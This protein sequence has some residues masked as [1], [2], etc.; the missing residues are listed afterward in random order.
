LW[1]FQINLSPAKQFAKC[2]RRER[3]PDCRS[4]D[5]RMKW[6]RL[7][8][9]ASSVATPARYQFSDAAGEGN[10]APHRL[11]AIEVSSGSIASRANHAPEEV[12]PKLTQ[13]RP[14]VPLKMHVALSSNQVDGH[15]R[16]WCIRGRDACAPRATE[17]G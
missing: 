9:T 5:K 3:L 8:L 15:E 2:D 16:R 11:A 13:D 6:R 4:I 14:P 10:A 1:K 12:V 7:L 17:Q